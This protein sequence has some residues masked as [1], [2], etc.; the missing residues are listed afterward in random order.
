MGRFGKRDDL[1]VHEAEPF[2][3]ERGG[4]GWTGWWWV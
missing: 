4:C 1:L 2:N 3:A